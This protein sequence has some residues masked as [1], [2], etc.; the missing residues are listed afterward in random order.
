MKGRSLDSPDGNMKSCSEFD[1]EEG[2]TSSMIMT[3]QSIYSTTTAA[4]AESPKRAMKRNENGWKILNFLTLLSSHIFLSSYFL[5][6]C[7]A[8]S[9]YYPQ[10]S[11]Q[12]RKVSLY[13]SKL[14]REDFLVSRHRE[15]QPEWNINN[16]LS[17]SLSSLP[18]LVE[19]FLNAFNF[20]KKH[21]YGICRVDFTVDSTASLSLGFYHQHLKWE[22]PNGWT[23]SRRHTPQERQSIC[24]IA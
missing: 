10:L 1:R 24:W 19:L 7:C 6:L 8:A 23:S 2:F 11:S 12:W 22:Y 18:F 5:L 20:A 9:L 17:N 14:S 15:S 16:F 13:Q 4:A 3:L 21:S